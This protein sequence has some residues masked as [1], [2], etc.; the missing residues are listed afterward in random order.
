[1]VHAAQ[2]RPMKRVASF[3]LASGP[4][5]SPPPPPRS[6]PPHSHLYSSPRRFPVESHLLLGCSHKIPNQASVTSKPSCRGVAAPSMAFGLP[7]CSTVASNTTL[8]P[9]SQ[10]LSRHVLPHAAPGF[11]TGCG[12]RD[13]WSFL[14][15]ASILLAPRD[16]TLVPCSG[17]CTQDQGMTILSISVAMV[18]LLHFRSKGQGHLFIAVEISIGHHPSYRWRANLICNTVCTWSTRSLS[19]IGSTDTSAAGLMTS[20]QS[21]SSSG[22]SSIFSWDIVH[23]WVATRQ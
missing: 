22:S 18:P 19:A 2:P 21:S 6:W 4:L 9:C 8:G 23:P 14:N 11:F 20:F 1:M 13:W 7:R 5:W 15:F 12:Y 10:G 3:L 16:D 17:G